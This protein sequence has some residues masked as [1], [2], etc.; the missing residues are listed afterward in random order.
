MPTSPP[1]LILAST[2]RYRHAL[3]ERLGLPFAIAAPGI[4]EAMLPGEPPAA[5][6]ARLA[7]AKAEAV[8]G[9]HPQAVVIGSDQV[10]ELDGLV[11]G[12]PGSAARAPAQ[13]ATSSP[14]T[15]V[16]YTA[17]ALARPDGARLS[18]T[19]RTRVRFRALG[20]SAIERYVARDQPLDCAGSFRS[21]GLGIALLAGIDTRDPTA[22]VGLPL[23]WLAAAL[24]DAGFDPLGG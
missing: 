4:D 9:V 23:V 13:L 21:E 17:V 7:R 16:F 11:V 14:R 8:A 20:A 3:L 10:A 2:S 1:R 19:D 6:A 15:L 18:H 22:L 12:K 24:A 5:L